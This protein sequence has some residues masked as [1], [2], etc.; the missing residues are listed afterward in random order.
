VETGC[1]GLKPPPCSAGPPLSVPLTSAGVP[2]AR[3]PLSQ[4]KNKS[5]ASMSCP[6]PN[7]ICHLSSLHRLATDF[8]FILDQYR[9]LTKC[10]CK[11]HKAYVRDEYNDDGR[12]SISGI[13]RQ[14]TNVLWFLIPAS[15]PRIGLITC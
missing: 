13:W 8:Q 11:T 15:S 1:C 4:Q 3:F 2:L 9:V 14:L 7:S 6:Q 10:P 12:S 5:T